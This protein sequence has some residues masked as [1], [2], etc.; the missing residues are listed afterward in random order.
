MAFLLDIPTFEDR[1]G[2]LSVLDADLPF[3]V[4]RIYYIY[5]TA[6]GVTRAGHRHKVNRQLLV[7]VAGRCE[8]RVNDG[9]GDRSFPLENP[10]T[11]LL[12]DASDWHLIRNLSPDAVLLVMASEAYDPG[13][14]IDEPYP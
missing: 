6:P 2:S 9:S 12:L 14:Y 10:H 7:C 8:I 4:R 11:G 3:P 13:D 1:R 5:G